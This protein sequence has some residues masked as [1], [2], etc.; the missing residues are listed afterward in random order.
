MSPRIPDKSFISICPV[1][2]PTLIVW[3]APYVV[4]L[5]NF[6]LLKVLK[7][8]P[9]NDDHVMLHSYNPD[10]DDIEI[11][12]SAILKLFRV[13]NVLTWHTIGV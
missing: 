4:Q 1:S 9:G 13:E 2:D 7:P 11:D 3:G 5:E 8:C 10:Y 6:R 12:R